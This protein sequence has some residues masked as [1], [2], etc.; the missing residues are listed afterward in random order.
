MLVP[1]LV[2]SLFDLLGLVCVRRG[3]LL[4]LLVFGFGGRGRGR[5]LLL[6][7]LFLVE[8]LVLFGFLAFL[9]NYG[10]RQRVRKV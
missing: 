10:R 9:L 3:G 1:P 5:G 8:L 6:F 4:D 2:P 7:G